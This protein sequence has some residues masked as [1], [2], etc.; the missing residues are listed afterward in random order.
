MKK[1]STGI[2]SLP[3]SKKFT[4]EF[5]ATYSAKNIGLKL[6][7]S[8]I[9]ADWKKEILTIKGQEKENAVIKKIAI[10]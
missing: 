6:K 7:I 8:F 3:P 9:T 2:I 1:L 5:L 4:K 10:L